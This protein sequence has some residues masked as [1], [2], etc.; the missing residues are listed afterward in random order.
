MNRIALLGLSFALVGCLQDSDNTSGSAEVDAS[1][2][3]ATQSADYLTSDVALVNY[4]GNG[5][6]IEE[7]LATTNPS[8][9]AIA[10]HGDDVYRIGRYTFDNLTKYS[11]DA[12]LG[13]LSYQ[14][15]YSVA[16]S[17][18]TGNPQDFVIYSDNVGYVSLYN[19]QYLLQVDP[20]VDGGDFITREID[21]SQFGNESDVPFMTD[22]TIVD[23]KLYVLLERLG[24]WWSVNDDSW[25]VVLDAA[26]GDIIEPDNSLSIFDPET[27]TLTDDFYINLGTSNASN[28]SVY[29]GTVYVAGRGDVYGGGD[30]AEDSRIVSFTPN[31]TGTDLTVT[32]V[33]DMS[34]NDGV[35]DLEGNIVSVDVS[36]SGDIYFSTYVSWGDNN[37]YVA[38]SLG[39][40]IALIS[41]GDSDS[42]NVADIAHGGSY[43]Y[44]AVHDQYDGI[45]G[46]GLKVFDPASAA[47]SDRLY[48][49]EDELFVDTLYNPTQIEVF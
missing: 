29:D 24:T 7:D 36:D 32:E 27:D 1:L 46:P 37:V 31:D 44:I 19:S 12:D 10:V 45:E 35:L 28:F 16:A 22:L 2:A 18:N 23:D 3:L 38:D 41:L 48:D 14:W 21:L 5:E 4:D 8:D 34:Y 49:V 40:N 25:V 20:N 47:V 17:D 9:I 26:T 6:V 13:A 30:L 39:E 43:V 33:I 11:W 15:Q 42:Y